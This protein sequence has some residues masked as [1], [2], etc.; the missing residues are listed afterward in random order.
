MS[1]LK[2]AVLRNELEYLQQGLGDPC[3]YLRAIRKEGYLTDEECQW[4]RSCTTDSEK[5][6]LFISM[7]CNQKSSQAFDVFVAE[8][9]KQRI[10]ASIASHLK[11]ALREAGMACEN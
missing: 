5:I 9:R 6:E 10:H 1:T 4:I 7:L 2:L 3:R 11:R 8:L